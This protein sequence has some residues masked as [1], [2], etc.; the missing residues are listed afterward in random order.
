V[1]GMDP[2]SRHELA[3]RVAEERFD[4]H[5]LLEPFDTVNSPDEKSIMT[6]IAALTAKL[7]DLG[8]HVDVATID[9]YST[10]ARAVKQFL[11]EKKTSWDNDPLPVTIEAIQAEV[12]ALRAFAANTMPDKHKEIDLLS[13]AYKDLEGKSEPEQL[14]VIVEEEIAPKDL[15][16]SFNAG[17]NAKKAREQRL[18]ALLKKKENEGCDINAVSLDC[19]ALKEKLRQ[20]SGEVSRGKESW[21]T[22]SQPEIKRDCDRIDGFIEVLTTDLD[23]ITKKYNEIAEYANDTESITPV[24]VKIDGLNTEFEKIVED[25]RSFMSQ[26]MKDSED[27]LLNKIKDLSEKLD[28]KRSGLSNIQW[29]ND[30]AV[31]K[32]CLDD[33]ESIQ[34]NQST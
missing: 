20:L 16:E 32:T 8:V 22:A 31:L 12:E 25:Y 26:H 5:Q 23:N 33:V 3:F 1:K 6:Y 30:L 9:D 4:V 24:A 19:D 2:I 14:K 29:T 7:P 34:K 10:H 18:L 28:A 13:K 11:V 21:P 17:I 27:S 15:S